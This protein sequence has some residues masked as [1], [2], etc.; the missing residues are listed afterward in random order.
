MKNYYFKS[1]YMYVKLINCTN[2]LIND[3]SLIEIFRYTRLTEGDIVLVDTYCTFDNHTIV[4]FS[5][6]GYR[7]KLEVNETCLIF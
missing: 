2:S 6:R 5:V 1:E 3:L 4:Y 7:C